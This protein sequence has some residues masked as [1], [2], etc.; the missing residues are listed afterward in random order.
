MQ[1]FISFFLKFKSNLLVKSLLLAECSFC[2]G[3]PGFNFSCTSSS[4]PHR[5]NKFFSSPNRP[6]RLCSRLYLLLNGYRRSFLGGKAAGG[7]KLAIH[8]HLASKLRMSIP[9]FLIPLLCYWFV[10]GCCFLLSVPEIF[11]ILTALGTN[12]LNLNFFSDPPQS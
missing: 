2:H 3:N 9:N 4:N 1:H 8:F 5:G 10:A 7:V 11:K 12:S 6:D